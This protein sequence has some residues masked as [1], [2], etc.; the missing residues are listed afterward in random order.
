MSFLDLDN[1]V[2]S[3]ISKHLSKDMNIS[4]TFLSK[5]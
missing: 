5:T 2:K 3:I 1:D 4:K